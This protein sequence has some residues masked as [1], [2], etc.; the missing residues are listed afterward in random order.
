[1]RSRKV[2]AMNEHRQLRLSLLL[3]FQGYG[4]KERLDNSSAKEGGAGLDRRRPTRVHA[5]GKEHGVIIGVQNH[6]DFLRTADDLI[7][8]VAMVDSPGVAR[9]STPV[10]PRSRP[11]CRDGEGGT[12]ARHRAVEYRRSIACG[13]GLHQQRSGA[14]SYEDS[15]VAPAGASADMGV[16]WRQGDD[17][18]HLLVLSLLAAWVSERAL[19]S[20]NHKDGPAAA[21]HL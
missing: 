3:E 10:F 18:S 6:G 19:R 7:K 11:L 13:V 20:D 1:M 4:L 9:S 21:G 17:G 14:T 5:F 16:R 8:L 12:V 2:K 15:V